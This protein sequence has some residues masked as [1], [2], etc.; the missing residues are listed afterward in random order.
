MNRRFLVVAPQGLGDALEATPLVSALKSASPDAAIDV[1]VL[2]APSRDLFSGLSEVSRV[3]YLPYWEKGVSGML[4]SLLS[5]G[6]FGRKRYD[7]A[8]LAYPAAR[9]E[10]AALFAMM[11]AKR[12]FLHEYEARGVLR[13]LA[14]AGAVSVPIRDA[15]NVERNLDLLR[16]AG[17]AF[18]APQSYRVPAS[19]ISGG[20]V[21]Q[22]RVVIHVG[23]IA[24]HGLEARRWPIERFEELARRCIAD[25]RTVVLLSGPAEREETR[26]LFE[27]LPGAEIFEDRLPAVAQLLSTSAAV[28]AND[29]GIAHLAAAVGAPTL[30]LFGPTS[31]NHAPYGPTSYPLRPTQCPP[32]FDVI[33][34]NTDCKL[35][36]D[37]ACLKR[38]LT[39]DVAYDALKT[40]VR[41]HVTAPA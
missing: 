8:F 32:C 19:W 36:I 10:Y 17:F 6:L 18:D 27:R 21:N 23:T 33:R 30:S 3:F 28:I 20:P 40:I 22:Q 41:Q 24:H 13:R 11:P 5:S 2:R 26:A 37:Y 16:A 1:L 34:T 25:G 31:L 29:S 9:A 38:D 35:R 14:N 39:V 12:R 15:H 4:S 7:A